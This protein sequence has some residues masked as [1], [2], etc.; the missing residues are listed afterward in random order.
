MER[1][2]I[3]GRELES[4]GSAIL[5]C[6]AKGKEYLVCER[7]N[8]KADDLFEGTSERKRKEA[9]GY[10]ASYAEQLR[11]EE[12]RDYIEQAIS[13]GM[14]VDGV[15]SIAGLDM[16]ES[17][18][19]FILRILAYIVVGFSVIAGVMVGGVLHAGFVG[20]VVALWGGMMALF[21]LVFLNMAKDARAVKNL[22]V[23]M[24]K[25]YEAQQAVSE[26]REKSR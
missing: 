25:K 26:A 24:M 12:V 17:G 14:P 4:E 13:D 22:L 6:G 16:S 19:G 2:C 21:C 3:C 18:S 9:A 15:E 20:V 1:C 8:E 5:F 7:C 23:F 11:E 10:F